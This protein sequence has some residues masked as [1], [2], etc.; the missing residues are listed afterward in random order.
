M[1]LGN[2]PVPEN[3]ALNLAIGSLAAFKDKVEDWK[4]AHP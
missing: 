1:A 2:L 4:E 3:I